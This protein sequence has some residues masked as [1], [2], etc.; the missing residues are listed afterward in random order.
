MSERGVERK[1]RLRDSIDQNK[2]KIKRAREREE[3]KRKKYHKREQ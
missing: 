3:I 2:D 1:R